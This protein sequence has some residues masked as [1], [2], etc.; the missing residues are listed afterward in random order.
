MLTRLGLIHL[1]AEAHYSINVVKTLKVP[2]RRRVFVPAHLGYRSLL[3]PNQLQRLGLLHCDSIFYKSSL[4][5][6]LELTNT[7]FMAL[8]TAT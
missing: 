7:P 1:T 5:F 8:V 3:T 6:P 4:G 2:S